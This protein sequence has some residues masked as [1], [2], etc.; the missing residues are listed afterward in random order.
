MCTHA[1]AAFL[2]AC[3]Q[4]DFLPDGHYQQDSIT[5]EDQQR[6]MDLFNTAVESYIAGAVQGAVRQ[7]CPA[8][9]R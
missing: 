5:L 6:R 9:Q 3:L 2:P 7:C 8:A 4:V 1:H